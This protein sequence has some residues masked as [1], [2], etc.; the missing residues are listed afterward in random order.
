MNADNTVFLMNQFRRITSEQMKISIIHRLS[1]GCSNSAKSNILALL[2]EI[3]HE[4]D[5][6]AFAV[7]S[8]VKIGGE[9]VNQYILSEL[10]SEKYRRVFFTTYFLPYLK[11]PKDV[12]NSIIDDLLSY[13]QP[14]ILKQALWVIR[15][16]K[17]TNFVPQVIKLLFHENLFVRREA[18]KAVIDMPNSIEYLTKTVNYYG[19]EKQELI[20]HLIA[21]IRKLNP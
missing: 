10:S 3:A 17:L 20:S 8:M 2:R 16:K 15:K 1:D 9:E 13:K 18:Q 4:E 5:Y 12:Y 7:A 6:Y 19:P 21:K 11:Y 14:M